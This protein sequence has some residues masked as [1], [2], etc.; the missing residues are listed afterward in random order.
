MSRASCLLSVSLARA[1]LLFA[2]AG[3]AI[4]FLK[5]MYNFEEPVVRILHKTEL[6]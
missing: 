1:F 5:G 3:L 4:L 6:I 2:L